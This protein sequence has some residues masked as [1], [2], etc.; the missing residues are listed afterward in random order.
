MRDDETTK[1]ETNMRDPLGLDASE[2]I[3][4]TIR[5]GLMRHA[6]SIQTID[7]PRD[8]LGLE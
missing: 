6:A 1:D 3:H 8:P 5:N 7:T 4:E 2:T